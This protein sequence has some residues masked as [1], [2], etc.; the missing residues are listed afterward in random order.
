MQDLQE[1]YKTDRMHGGS[2]NKIGQAC[3]VPD[4]LEKKLMQLEDDEW[5]VIVSCPGEKLDE[6]KA[7]VKAVNR[8]IGNRVLM[9]ML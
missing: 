4:K 6:T 7:I 5:A 1:A 9:A 8:K 3:V 2:Y